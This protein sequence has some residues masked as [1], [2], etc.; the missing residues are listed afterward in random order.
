MKKIATLLTIG[1]AALA[2][3]GCSASG[4]NPA[5]ATR[6]C[7]LG[8]NALHMNIGT[9]NLFG[10]SATPGVPVVGTNVVVT[11]RQSASANCFPGNSGALVSEPT[12]TLPLAAPVLGA[13]AG[14]A[15]GFGATIATGPAASEIGTRILTA[16]TQSPTVTNNLASA[17]TFGDD[18]GAFGLGLEPWN[19]AA[20]LGTAGV[21]GTPANVVP[22]AVPLYDGIVADPN[23]FIPG[24]GLPAFNPAGNLAAVDMGFNGISEGLD[25]FELPP[26][27][28]S[29]TLSVAVPANTGTV[30]LPAAATMSSLALLPNVTPAVMLAGSTAGTPTDGGGRFT[31][32]IPPGLREAYVEVT[33]IG[34]GVTGGA[35]CQTNVNGSNAFVGPQSAGFPVINN[36]TYYTFETP[37]GTYTFVVP[38]G[39]F[40]SAAQNA[41]ATATVDGNPNVTPPAGPVDGDEIAV[42]TI[43]FDYGAYEMSY[44]NSL[45]VVAPSLAGTGGVPPG[46]TG[47]ADITVSTKSIYDQPSGGGLVQIQSLR[48]IRRR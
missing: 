22:Y 25:V 6:V 15:D 11:F 32:T 36:P 27:L 44:P 12:L 47:Q 40:C 2:L 5:S 37:P 8:A 33:N 7:N 29:Y 10:N 42:Q 21:A 13:P 34:P 28:G 18:G 16:L 41:T 20:P 9:A 23:Q 19:Y 4:V 17:A 39:S 1:A 38:A 46:S 45:G 43:G 24:G 26:A 3:A 14:T 35:T 30:T 31:V 48:G